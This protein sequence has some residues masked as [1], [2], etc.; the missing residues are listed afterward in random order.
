MSDTCK[1]D[2][3]KTSRSLSLPRIFLQSSLKMWLKNNICIAALS[4]S[5]TLMRDLDRNIGD[6]FIALKDL[7]G[8]IDRDQNR[9]NPGWK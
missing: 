4:S 3:F 6:Q 8:Y 5:S 9:L 2:P 1:T 7:R